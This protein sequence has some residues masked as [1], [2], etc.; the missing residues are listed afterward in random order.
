MAG[1]MCCKEKR[2]EEAL[3][4]LEQC[5]YFGTV[6]KNEIAVSALAHLVK[7]ALCM[8]DAEKARRYYDMLYALAPTAK[9]TLLLGLRVELLLERRV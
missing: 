8:K 9:A 3:L 2:Y 5:L 7:T 4:M 1:I 6:Y